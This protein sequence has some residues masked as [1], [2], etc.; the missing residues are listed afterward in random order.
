MCEIYTG[1]ASIDS[2]KVHVLWNCWECFRKRQKIVLAAFR[3]KFY[4]QNLSKIWCLRLSVVLHTSTWTIYSPYRIISVF[5]PIPCKVSQYFLSSADWQKYGRVL[6]T[7]GRKS[8]QSISRCFSRGLDLHGM[9]PLIIAGVPCRLVVPFLGGA[10][11][12]SCCHN[13]ARVTRTP[14]FTT[15]PQKRNKMEPEI[16]LSS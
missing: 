15:S 11:K 1:H 5:S 2:L 9:E 8:L 10:S 16:L 12:M 13:T 6:A 14:H 7:D 3:P 4:W